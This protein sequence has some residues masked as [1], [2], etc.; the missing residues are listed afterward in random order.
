VR[1]QLCG[2]GFVSTDSVV[3]IGRV[4]EDTMTIAVQPEGHLH[5]RHFVLQEDER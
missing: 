2:D 4:V 3:T 5:L 1:C